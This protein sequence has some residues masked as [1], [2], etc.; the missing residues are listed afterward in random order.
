MKLLFNY[1]F[2]SVWSGAFS[3]LVALPL[4]II[5]KII[6][7][8]YL[9]IFGLPNY[10]MF[11]SLEFKNFSDI[12]VPWLFFKLVTICLVFTIITFIIGITRATSTNKD[13]SK[14]QSVKSVLKYSFLFGFIMLCLPF[15]L[16]FL[17]VFINLI[18]IAIF[19]GN[20]I[21]L[22]KDI[23]ISLYDKEYLYDNFSLEHWNDL[24][25]D[26][27]KVPFNDYYYNTKSGGNSLLLFKGLFVSWA[28]LIP[29]LISSM[30]IIT[31]LFHQFVL[32]IISPLVF[33]TASV[34]N[35]VR[36]KEWMKMYVSK[37]VVIIGFL[38][39]IQI[40]AIFVGRAISWV[41]VQTN[42]S[43]I[44]KFVLICLFLIGG[45]L[46][47]MTVTEIFA[48]FIGEK[49][50]IRESMGEMK[51]LFGLGAGVLAGA[52]ATKWGLGH[53]STSNHREKLKRLRRNK[54]DWKQ[55][56]LTREQYNNNIS[57]IKQKA[58]DNSI[59]RNKIKTPFVENV[60]NPLMNK[61]EYKKVQSSLEKLENADLQEALKMMEQKSPSP[62]LQKENSK[63]WKQR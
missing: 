41:N 47:N 48:S 46:G 56:R 22:G 11:G 6:R 36:M 62:T 59:Y 18:S 9:I 27:Y 60:K 26:G 38:I 16:Y 4:I 1:L 10:L 57:Q 24:S 63:W 58:S 44:D 23:W 30:L 35:G 43:S 54:E 3:F 13:V 31:K 51:T 37:L 45:A 21:Q 40:Y 32:F 17:N 25:N 52:K 14:K 50:S 19:S 39:G 28:T 61:V 29:L 42:L 34:D 20:E 33:S 55:G 49:A 2:Y 53:L 15:L 7:L 12:N 5:D 8:F